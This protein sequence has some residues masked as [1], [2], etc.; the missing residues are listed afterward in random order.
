MVFRK[1]RYLGDAQTRRKE[2]D[3]G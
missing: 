1:G 3:R 2:G